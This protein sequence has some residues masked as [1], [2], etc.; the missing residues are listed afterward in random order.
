[1]AELAVIAADGTVNKSAANQLAEVMLD[2]KESPRAL[3]ARLG[4]VQVQDAD[5][6]AKWIDAA[7]ASNQQ[8]VNDALA[9]PKKM[10][11]AAGFLRGQVMKLSAGKADPNL[12]GKLIEERIRAQTPNP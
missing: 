7:F 2:R 10:Q 12:V 11:A 6:T 3:A 5:A 4:L 1:M 8:A 9:N